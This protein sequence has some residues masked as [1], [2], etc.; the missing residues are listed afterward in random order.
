MET[1]GH[2]YTISALIAVVVGAVHSI[3]GEWKVLRPLYENRGA[4]A[5]LSIAGARRVIRAVWHMPSLI[6]AA[7]GIVTYGFVYHDTQPPGFFV[8]YASIIYLIGAIGNAWSL[9]KLHVGSLLLT[10]AAGTLLYGKFVL[11]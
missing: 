1:A 8:I 6:W 11:S 3:L 9:R 2:F 7:T 4:S 10:L 5:A